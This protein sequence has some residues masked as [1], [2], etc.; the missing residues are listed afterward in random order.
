M[1]SNL[2]SEF[3]VSSGQANS[4]ESPISF[5]NSSYW[6]D[7]N[8]QVY[9]RPVS[10]PN[11]TDR[12]IIINNQTYQPL[13]IDLG[14]EVSFSYRLDIQTS[15]YPIIFMNNNNGS[16]L[17][18]KTNNSTIRFPQ[19]Y[20]GKPVTFDVPVISEN[21]GQTKISLNGDS[22]IFNNSFTS[23]GAVYF[24]D[25]PYAKTITFNGAVNI[26][27]TFTNFYYKII[28][29]LDGGFVC[30][31]IQYPHL[32]EYTAST[33]SNLTNLTGSSPFKKTGSGITTVN[34]PD[35]TGII[36]VFDGTVVLGENTNQ[37]VQVVVKAGGTLKGN[38]SYNILTVES[39]G[40][41]N[42]GNSPGFQTV[43]TL[44][45]ETDS[46]TVWELG[47]S[48]TD[49]RGTN[50]DA[51]NVTGTATIA[52][53]AKLLINV[54]SVNMGE[55]FWS[56]PQVWEFI[57]ATALAGNK[58]F[59]V[60][61]AQ[62]TPDFNETTTNNLGTFYSITNHDSN[63]ESF[64]DLINPESKI[65]VNWRSMV[66]GGG[67]PHIKP[68]FGEKYLLENREYC[69]NLFNSMI[70]ND[71]IMIN[72]KCWFL[73]AEL[74]EDYIKITNDR[75]S[76]PYMTKFT[77]FRY[78]S[79]ICGDEKLVIDME[80]LKT[81]EYTSEND[82]DAFNLKQIDE[83]YKFNS[84]HVGDIVNYDN[85]LYSVAQKRYKKER[86]TITR[87]IIVENSD[88]Y[89]EVILASNLNID[90]RNSIS[91]KVNSKRKMC[92]ENF[93]G[94]LIK[95]CKSRISKLI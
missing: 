85:G 59:N 4:A 28:I 72:A 94:A 5:S 44:N 63:A 39:G 70:G 82:V 77:F 11:F 2:I 61:T 67:D 51:I 75:N 65:I 49:G 86:D 73:P 7:V 26:N 54:S 36:T 74:I 20:F 35:F 14:G 42:I 33:A 58:N 3:R 55:I 60:I 88:C 31:E 32:I 41:L 79:F 76:I 66:G 25:G 90:D 24:E 80:T 53:G 18:L 34:S 6:Y 40:I 92:T 62:G 83:T 8:T 91:L 84:I 29:N 81:V 68:M 69:Y 27:G 78:L 23:A 87:K 95:N 47:S 93:N 50:Y 19:N 38:G 37:N 48:T 89:V 57:S 21:T 1:T 13:Y 71:K 52:S 30:G 46:I 64:Y 17:I 22:L 15:N 12:N 43:D 45:L 16:K 56:S 9:E 10:Y